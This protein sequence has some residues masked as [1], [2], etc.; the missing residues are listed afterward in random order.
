MT[1]PWER[2]APHLLACGIAR[3]SGHAFG[4]RKASGGTKRAMPTSTII[5]DF[6]LGGVRMGPAIGVSCRRRQNTII[7]LTNQS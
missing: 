1:R 7:D 5:F 2:S 6:H 3:V 4:V